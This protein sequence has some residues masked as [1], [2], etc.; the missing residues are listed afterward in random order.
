MSPALGY[1]DLPAGLTQQERS[2]ALRVRAAHAQMEALACEATT[3]KLLAAA[4]E[5]IGHSHALL[6]ELREGREG[7]TRQAAEILGRLRDQR[8][9]RGS[10][11]NGDPDDAGGA[12]TGPGGEG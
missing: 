12:M 3:R 11:S 6:L 10:T 5:A 8:A 7:A 1:G 2:A 4:A 9:G